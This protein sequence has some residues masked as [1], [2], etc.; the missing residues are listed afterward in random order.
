MRVTRENLN[1]QKETCT[2]AA[3]STSYPTLTALEMNP[4]FCGGMLVTNFLHHVRAFSCNNSAVL[5][6]EISGTRSITFL[7]QSTKFWCS[8]HVISQAIQ[9]IGPRKGIIH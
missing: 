6:S 2:S 3:L 8:R 5:F 1:T 7:C 4:R 9:I